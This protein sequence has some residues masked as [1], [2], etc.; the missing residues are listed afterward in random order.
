MSKLLTEPVRITAWSYSRYNDY[1]QCPFK[2]KCK[3]ILK[4]KE[5]GSVAMDRGSDIHKKIEAYLTGAVKRVPPEAKSL[6]KEYKAI[7]AKAPEVERELAFNS[8]WEPCSWFD[9]S[10]WCRVKM[11]AVILPTVGSDGVVTVIDHKTGNL[12]ESGEYDSQ[13]SLYGLAGLISYP[14]ADTVI[15]KLLFVDHGREVFSDP[16]P[17]KE[18]KKLQ[19]KWEIMV[20]TMLSD[21]KFRPIPGNYCRWCHFRKANGGPCEY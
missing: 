20:K 18:L 9:R 1:Q 6:E 19:K 4:L 16:I 11:D 3:I 8:K 17:R 13:L 2:A 14:T 15:S 5:P 21:T 10:A 7:K 12:K